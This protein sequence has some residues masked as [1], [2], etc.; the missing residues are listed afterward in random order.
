MNELKGEEIMPA[1]GNDLVIVCRRSI[2]ELGRSQCESEEIVKTL[3]AVHQTRTRATSR[4][5]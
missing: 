5:G 3:R 1:A 2:L 4:T